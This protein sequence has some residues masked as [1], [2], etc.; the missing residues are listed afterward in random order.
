MPMG[1]LRIIRGKEWFVRILK[2]RVY[3]NDVE[4]GTVAFNDY[5]DFIVPSGKLRLFVKIDVFKSE[6]QEVEIDDSKKSIFKIGLPDIDK[7]MGLL[8]SLFDGKSQI[9]FE[10]Q[11]TDTR[12]NKY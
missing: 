1:Q 12:A 11:S 5:R 10:P 9:E 3:V 7:P 8:A 6:V 4:V 2:L